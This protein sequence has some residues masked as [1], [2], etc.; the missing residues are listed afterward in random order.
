MQGKHCKLYDE[1]LVHN[2]MVSTALSTFEY[3]KQ[4]REI[5]LEEICEFVEQNAPHIIQSTI[6][7]MNDAEGDLDE[8]DVH[9]DGEGNR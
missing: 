3:V 5:D 6:D 4:K 7:E 8:G 1:T 9:R 2:I